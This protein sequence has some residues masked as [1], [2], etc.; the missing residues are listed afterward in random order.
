M[1]LTKR[2][3]SRHF[4]PRKHSRR[5][6][7]ANAQLQQNTWVAHRSIGYKVVCTID[8]DS[9]VSGIRIPAGREIAFATM[10]MRDRWLQAQGRTHAA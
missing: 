1:S 5:Y 8:H 2:G 4:Q 7:L 10:Q 6:W 3:N 9:I